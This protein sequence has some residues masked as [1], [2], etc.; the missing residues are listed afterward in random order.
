M[1]Y[2][3]RDSIWENIVSVFSKHSKIKKI[4]LYGSRA[5]GNYKNGSDIDLTLVGD[6]INVQDLHKILVEL[7]DLCLP[8]SF[9]LSIFEKI[10]NID[11]IEHIK[12]IGTTIYE[13]E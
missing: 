4:I 2:G 11:L 10:E 5:K 8:Y 6:N 13:K 3:I 1:K 9:D 12:K 7:D